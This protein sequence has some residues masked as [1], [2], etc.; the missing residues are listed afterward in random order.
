MQGNGQEGDTVKDQVLRGGGPGLN[1]KRGEVWVTGFQGVRAE[2]C[3]D[4]SGGSA[5]HVKHTSNG[6]PGIR[7]SSDDTRCSWRGVEG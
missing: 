7:T 1:G 3:G 5:R 4:Q 6:D 2:S